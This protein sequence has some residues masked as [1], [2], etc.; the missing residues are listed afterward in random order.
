MGS[1]HQQTAMRDLTFWRDGF[2][3]E[4][5][6]LRRY[7][8][9]AQA[10]IQSEINAGRASSS[11]LIVQPGQPV[12]LRVLRRNRRGLRTDASERLRWF[13]QPSWRYRL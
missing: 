8:D 13:R 1:R 6:E 3:V 7:D 10:Q 9:P 12:E 5:G 4:G 11:I 2:S